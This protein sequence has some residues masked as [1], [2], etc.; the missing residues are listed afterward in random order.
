M[1]VV[2]GQITV[3][4]GPAPVGTLVE[5]LTP[6]GEV[7]GCA[8]VTREG[9]YGMMHVYGADDTAQPAIEGLWIE[10]PLTFRVNG[11]PASSL[12]TVLWENDK[13]THQT[14]LYAVIHN[15]YLPL[16]ERGW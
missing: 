7:A 4:S 14:A 1:T 13:M 12:A 3:N 16:I 6:R 11:V 8:L 9:Q 10:E 15:T 2:Y 5:V